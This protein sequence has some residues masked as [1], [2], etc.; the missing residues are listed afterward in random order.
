MSPGEAYVWGCVGGGVTAIALFVLPGLGHAALTNQIS[1]HLT[2]R[3][4]AEIAALVL[5]YSAVAGVFALIP[6]N[7]TRGQAILIGLGFQTT[8]KSVLSGAKEAFSP[9]EVKS[10]PE[11]VS[12]PGPSS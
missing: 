6:T 7:P 4:M 5:L 12:D 8:L 11:L 3:R 2:G 1:A 9:P 10:T